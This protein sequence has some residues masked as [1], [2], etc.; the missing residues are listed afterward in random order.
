MRRIIHALFAAMTDTIQ[1][2]SRVRSAPQTGTPRALM[3]EN[4]ISSECR[5]DVDLGKTDEEFV[6]A[7]IA[8]LLEY[9]LLIAVQIGMYSVSFAAPVTVIFLGVWY[10]AAWLVVPPFIVI[11]AL[12][13]ARNDEP[14]ST[15]K[16][17]GIAVITLIVLAGLFAL[18]IP[19]PGFLLFLVLPTT[20]VLCAPVLGV[21]ALDRINA[22]Y[23][24]LFNALM[25]AWVIVV[26]AGWAWTITMPDGR[27]AF[28]GE[29]R[30][31]AEEALSMVKPPCIIRGAPENI[32]WGISDGESKWRV[33]RI[34]NLGDGQYRAT[35]QFYTW[36]RIPT[37]AITVPGCS[38]IQ[39]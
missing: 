30:A 1:A 35:V 22:R 2:L 8:R 25:L 12:K 3:T 5:S 23:R 16:T 39:E 37:Y 10:V 7:L 31:Q 9:L 34:D 33:T 19:I 14:F 36:M 21:I 6:K 20:F 28:R 15:G 38:R 18:A 4:E 17:A 24:I 29:Q 27:D 32:D 11:G 13:I 26:V